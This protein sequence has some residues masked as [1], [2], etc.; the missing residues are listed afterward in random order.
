MHTINASHDARVRTQLIIELCS[1]LTRFLVASGANGDA[2]PPK[3]ELQA[4]NDNEPVAYPAS[5]LPDDPMTLREVQFEL[6]LKGSQVVL[7]RRLWAF[8]SP[9]HHGGKIIFSRRAVERWVRLQPNPEN[10][11]AVLRLRRRRVS[12]QEQDI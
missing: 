3:A 10:L 7:L 11:A 1:A 9:W 2:L 12:R 4:A 6:R 5:K 8:P